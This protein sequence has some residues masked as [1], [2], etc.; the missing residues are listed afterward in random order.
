MLFDLNITFYFP[1]YIFLEID[2]CESMPCQNNATC[3]DLLNGY[4]CTCSP[5]YTGI[6]CATGK[7]SWYR[8]LLKDNYATG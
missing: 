5:G 7:P 3:T 2:E 4:N 1:V 6:E 8:L